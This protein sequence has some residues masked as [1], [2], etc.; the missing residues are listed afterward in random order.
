MEV[1]KITEQQLHFWK[2]DR[3]KVAIE[4]T[5]NIYVVKYHSEHDINIISTQDITI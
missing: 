3:T 2:W 4:E 1:E 5:G